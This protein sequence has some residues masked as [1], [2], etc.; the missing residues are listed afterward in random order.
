VGHDLILPED[1][2]KQ[3]KNCILNPGF[4]ISDSCYTVLRAE[5]YSGVPP[6]QSLL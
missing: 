5:D 6:E 1:F 3:F 4:V 2:L